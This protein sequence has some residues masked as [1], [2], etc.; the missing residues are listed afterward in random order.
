MPDIALTLS[1]AVLK[2]FCK[3]WTRD[4]IVADN[5]SNAVI[6]LTASQIADTRHQRKIRN[7]FENLEERIADRILTMLDN[8]FR[9]VPQNER[10][11]AIL[12]V[13]DTFETA[14]LTND[15]L[16]SADLDPLFLERQIR[17]DGR[18]RT[19]DLSEGAVEL[20]NRILAGCCAY[21][22]ELANALPGFEVGVFA[23]LL[24]RHTELLTRV[25]QLFDRLPEITLDNAGNRF[26]GAYRQLVAKQLDRLELF[27]VTVSE[28][29]NSC[30]LTTAYIS[31]NVDSAELQKRILERRQAELTGAGRHRPSAQAERLSIEEALATTSR[32]FLRGEA[33]S[34]KTTVLQWIAVRSALR[35]FRG[36]L[37][38]WNEQVPFLIQLRQ[39]AGRELPAPE[40]FLFSVG[41]HIAEEMPDRWINDKLRA[42]EAV[43]LVDGVDE[44]PESQRGEARAWLRQ[45]LDSY[46]E[47]RYVVTSRPSAVTEAWLENEAF[48][49][50]EIQPMGITDIEA[51]IG[52]W[53]EAFR[54]RRPDSNQAEIGLSERKLLEEIRSHRHL[55]QLA[56]S[57][58]LTALLCALS[59]DRRTRL[60]RDRMELYGV[61][62]EMLL[63]RRD[64]ERG[65]NN[66]EGSELSRADRMLLLQEFAYWL[67]RNNWSD[68]PV[69]RVESLLDQKLRSILHVD[70]SGKHALKVLVDR[71]GIL[72]EPVVGRIDFVH[73]TFQ[74]YF[75]ASA[76]VNAD[77]IGVLVS[78]ANSDQWREVI[79]MAA[80]HAL[81]HQRN[82]LLRKLID[83]A[84]GSGARSK[85]D[86]RALLVGCMETSH[87]IDEDLLKEIE[88]ITAG[89][90]PPHSI[91]QAER[92]AAAGEF[93][94]DRLPIDS[95]RTES[96]AA[97][98]VRLASLVGGPK[99]LPIISRCAEI[100]GRNVVDQVQQAWTLFD[101]E[102]YAKEV[103]SKLDMSYL[104]ISDPGLLPGLAFLPVRTLALD[105]RSGYG[106]LTEVGR[107]KSLINLIISDPILSDLTP[108]VSSS[109][110]RSLEVRRSATY[111]LA[112]IAKVRGLTSLDLNLRDLVDPESISY[113]DDLNRLQLSGMTEADR[114]RYMLSTNA[115]LIRLGLW[116]AFQIGDLT[117]IL[118][119]PQ[120]TELD[121]LLLDKCAALRTISGIEQWRESMTGL[122]LAAP[123][124]T[125]IELVA[126]LHR[127]TF[128]NLRHTAISDLS[129]VTALPELNL[130]HL[131]GHGPIPDLAP[132]KD[133]PK[134]RR[135]FIWS[136]G[137][138]DL[139]P[140]AG[141]DNLAINV[142]GSVRK[143]KAADH[144]G[145]SSRLLVVDGKP[146]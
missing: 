4:N 89:L 42:G 100:R 40:G 145:K 85:S 13:R 33:G 128:L 67:I 12:A 99:A 32:L 27:G 66:I 71:S 106:D 61:A 74:E 134:L 47:A 69:E 97:A 96:R 117:D 52:H 26:E 81:F 56:T 37:T 119:L 76:A 59:V 141:V 19:R 2:T 28:A 6:D 7:L 127:L 11:A 65:I 49:P 51:F 18:S 53:H 108:L 43:I 120:T 38:P 84:E 58:L 109:T 114:L 29:V 39:Y 20:Y 62:L 16:F 15:D 22:V 95:V 34:G 23:T 80:G 123:R 44:L 82:E 135:L 110:L 87:Q 112:P 3:L 54:A 35:D 139:T 111:K 116:E 1:A 8:E 121:F 93:V 144:L 14:S 31:L 30:S 136:P 72:R 78:H 132:L 68:A 103:L 63:E 75:A 101:P 77:D 118:R 130:L 98:T 140:L 48:D 70:L 41:R 105:F 124:V 94:L 122:Y 115:K 142:H 79:V 113:L 126:T 129:F 146:L 10:E 64:T 36:P 90:L 45:L 46:P 25:D 24:T 137:D 88:D 5:I 57:P 107:L 102:T 50:A 21:I 73:R 17:K 131:G 125:D 104:R 55:R 9:D 86:L 60:P 91:P 83:R 138:L 133:L 143:V 92:L